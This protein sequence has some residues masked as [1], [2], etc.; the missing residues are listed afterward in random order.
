[1]LNFNM[2][3]QDTFCLV[4]SFHVRIDEWRQKVSYQKLFRSNPVI[5]R[6]VNFQHF[7]FD[8]PMKRT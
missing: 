3:S 1:M 8:I 2:N 4:L 6:L 5:L 7:I